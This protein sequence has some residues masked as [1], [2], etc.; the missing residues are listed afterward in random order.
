MHAFELVG[1]IFIMLQLGCWGLIELEM[2]K[3]SPVVTVGLSENPDQ[4]YS[5]LALFLFGWSFYCL[6][7]RIN[8][9]KLTAK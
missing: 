8:L 4:T 5:F 6:R 9:M 1:Y 7:S 3:S 2:L